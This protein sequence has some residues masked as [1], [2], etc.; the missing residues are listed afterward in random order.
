MNLLI[1]AGLVNRRSAIASGAAAVGAVLAAGEGRTGSMP[2]TMPTEGEVETVENLFI[3]TDDG[4]KLAVQLWLP[5]WPRRRPA[6]VVL[7]AIP[8]RKRDRYRAYGAFWGLSLARRGVA[9]ARLDCRGSGDSTGLLADEYLPREQQDAALAIAWLAA[10]PWCNGAVGMRGVSWGGFLTL[11]TAALR[12]PSLRAIMPMCASDRRYLDD[13]HYVGG[14]FGLTGLKWATSMRLVQAGPP[15][16]QITGEA[17][18][19]VWLERLRAAPPI[20]GR[21]LSHQTEDDYWR[22]GSIG[23]DW[24]AIACPVYAVGGLIDPYSPAI[25]RLLENL[26]VPSKALIGPWRHGYPLPAQP[27]PALDWAFE[28]IRWW[29]QWLSAEETGLMS[30][31]AFRVF[32]AEA[33]AAQVAPAPLPGR[34]VAEARWPSASVSTRTLHL[35]SGSLRDDSAP[36][37]SVRLDNAKLVGLG[38]IEWVPFAPSEL[39]REQSADDARSAVFDTAPLPAPMEI[40]GGPSVRLRLSADAGRGHVAARLCEVTPDGRSWLVAWGLL[41]LTRRKGPG[42]FDLLVPG[43]PL[44]VEIPLGFVS[45]RFER[46]ARLRL[47]L[48]TS[49]W[50]L[51][52]PARDAADVEVF[53]QGSRLELPIRNPPAAEATMPIAEVQGAP[54][55][56]G[57]GPGLTITEAEGGARIVETWPVSTSVAPDVG[58]TM[59]GSGPDIDVSMRPGDP[60]TCA[61]RAEQTSGYRHSGGEITLRAV[62]SITAP[63]GAY[64]VEEETIAT[65]NGR[66]VAHIRQKTSVPRL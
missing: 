19:D 14:A 48:S 25:P 41:D 12:P 40:L 63:A 46:G 51:V 11:Q 3:P 44:E 28:E 5:A 8:Y 9:Y 65:L 23:L 56:S 54:E 22:Q 2:W 35:G 17:W 53:L 36:E 37:G 27:G 30:E 58:V 20:A 50:P 24:E 16:P 55:D 29:R 32:M 10:Q 52:W 39:P 38:K 15:D 62:V 57:K 42:R 31:P 4:E 45:Q 64:E 34:W 49:L 33:T 1:D 26:K 60:A 21:W 66:T 47:A 6:P 43:R 18:K 59:S 13:A 7:E 61:W